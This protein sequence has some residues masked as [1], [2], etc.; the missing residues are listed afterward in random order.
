MAVLQA[1]NDTA[2]R[3]SAN[4]SR[5]Y[6]GKYR[7]T[8]VN[9]LDPLGLGRILAVVPGVA[10]FIP[11]TWATPC[12]PVVGLQVGIYAVPIIGSGVWMEFEQ[13]DPDHPIWVGCYVGNPA[14]V[15]AL[16]RLTPPGLP[17]ITLQTTLGNGLTINDLSASPAG[18]IV[19]K[20]V[21]G[22]S[23]IVNDTGIYIQNGK[24]ASLT[25]IGPTVN[26]NAGALT[27]T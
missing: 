18:G 11:G 5:R 26:V 24:G 17:S 13:G 10:G 22:A 6:Y 16:S 27:V 19:I 3:P 14:D 15:P 7:G 25:M 21:T 2:T 23:I 20:S 9:N 8:V 1:N 4:T 12:L